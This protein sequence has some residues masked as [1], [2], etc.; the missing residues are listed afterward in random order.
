MKLKIANVVL[1]LLALAEAVFM[2]GLIW[3]TLKAPIMHDVPLDTRLVLTVVPG[4]AFGIIVWITV[5]AWKSKRS[6]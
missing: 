5:D 4:I 2:L 3:W 1:T 6:L